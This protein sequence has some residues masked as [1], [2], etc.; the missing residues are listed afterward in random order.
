LFSLFLLFYFLY[1]VGGVEKRAA[2]IDA[3]VF[4]LKTALG[5]VGKPTENDGLHGDWP[6]VMA[7]ARVT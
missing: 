3:V 1:P 4:D 2:I 5:G 6:C 7:T